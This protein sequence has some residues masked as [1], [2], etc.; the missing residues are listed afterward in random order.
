MPSTL[1]CLGRRRAV[2]AGLLVASLPAA[3]GA[4]P[5]Y[6]FQIVTADDSAVSHHIVEDLKG[7][8]KWA[9]TATIPTGTVYIT[10][11][12]AALRKQLAKA[13]D[14]VIISAFT[15]GDVFRSLVAAAPKAQA[16]RTTALFA[17]PAP[18]DQFALI[19]SLYQRPVKIAALLGKQATALANALRAQAQ[20]DGADLVVEQIDRQD[21]NQALGQLGRAQVLLAVP[22][23]AIVHVDTIRTILLTTYRRN[24]GVIGFSSDMVQAGALATMYSDIEDINTQ[25]A[26]MVAQVAA[27]G[28]LPMPQYPR[29]VKVAVN[30]GVARSLGV[31]VGSS[32]M[33]LARARPQRGR[34]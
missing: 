14:G 29:Y 8:L 1:K 28:A 13:P 10:I 32:V 20:Q 16:G 7:R 31:Q 30:E 3:V 17:E 23:Q 15:S 6:G 22:D 12:P 2:L 9:L 4:A 18:H 21:L 19:A 24:M 34:P 11:G 5:A 25:L 33:K 26:D 27:S